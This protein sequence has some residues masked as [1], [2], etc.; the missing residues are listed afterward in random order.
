MSSSLTVRSPMMALSWSRSRSNS[1]TSRH[2]F[3]IA[4]LLARVPGATSITGSS[5]NFVSLRQ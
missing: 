3:S 1:S 4:Q 5:R 2:R